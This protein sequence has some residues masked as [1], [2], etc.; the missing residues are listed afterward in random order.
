MMDAE[1]ARMMGALGRPSRAAAAPSTDPRRTTPKGELKMPKFV[2]FHPE[3]PATLLNEVFWEDPNDFEPYH[4]DFTG[5]TIYWGTVPMRE[6]GHAD[7]NP[8]E[9]GGRT[10]ESQQAY[11]KDS[12][13]PEIQFINVLMEKKKAAM[14]EVD[15]SEL[16]KRDYT[17]DIHVEYMP[18]TKK[19][20]RKIRVSGGLSLAVFSDKVMKP[21]FGLVRNLHAHIFQDFSDGSQFGPR[22]SNAI[23]VIHHLDKTGYAYIPDDEYTL[24]HFLRKPGDE[25]GYL[26]DFGDN[27]HFLIKVAEIAPVEEST[28]KVVVLG[29]TGAHPP[30]GVAS[31]RWIDLMQKVDASA[32]DRKAALDVLYESSGYAG[33]RW[34]PHFDFAEFSVPATQRAVAAAVAS[35][36]SVPG[37]AKHFSAL[38]AA[39]ADDALVYPSTLKKGQRLVRTPVPR[40]DG[41]PARVF[42]EEGVAQERRD[43]PANTACANC[44]SPHGLKACSGCKQRYYCSRSC[45]RAN[46]AQGHK[47]VCT[48]GKSK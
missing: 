2:K 21:L 38:L 8:W 34:D 29:G 11:T 39:G 22:D 42:M 44:G 35:K 10:M 36:L 17:L 16:S 4:S 40:A 25:L 26:Y 20:E 12:P 32:K 31:W 46:W 13:R 6:N 45:Q 15:I 30:D 43:N 27:W 14:K 7:I 33:Q 48:G 47:K 41:A 1:L 23:D 28:G 9:F 3:D 37:G 24:A 19:I 5:R 18:E